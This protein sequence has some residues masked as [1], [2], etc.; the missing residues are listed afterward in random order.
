[1]IDAQHQVREETFD[2]LKRLAIALNLSPKQLARL[3]RRLRLDLV[4]LR[5]H[6]EREVLG[7]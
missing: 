4:A 6:V 1:M 5:E 2:E 7:R 3:C